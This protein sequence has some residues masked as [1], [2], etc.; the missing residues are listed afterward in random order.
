[1]FTQLSFSFCWFKFN[2][3]FYFLCFLL[4]D[5]QRLHFW[6]LTRLHTRRCF[7]DAAVM[8]YW[9]HFSMDAI[10][11]LLY[12]FCSALILC[13]YNT[14]FQIILLFK[15]F[16]SLWVKKTSSFSFCVRFNPFSSDIGQNQ[17]KSRS[18]L[19]ILIIYIHL[20]SNSVSEV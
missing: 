15:A 14:N 5:R 1:M 13:Q 6:S 3:I 12:W 10:N 17:Q 9:I 7:A 11:I 19:H 2:I 18:L 4:C 16:M 8:K 20:L